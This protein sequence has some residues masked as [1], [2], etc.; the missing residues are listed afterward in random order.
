MGCSQQL[1]RLLTFAHL[2]LDLCQFIL[3]TPLWSELGLVMKSLF[4]F[5]LFS[6]IGFI[7]AQQLPPGM[8]GAPAR[9]H[10][11]MSSSLL[12]GEIVDQNGFLIPFIDCR[13]EMGQRSSLCLYSFCL[14]L[15]LKCSSSALASE[16]RQFLSHSRRYSKKRI[17]RLGAVKNRT[18]MRCQVM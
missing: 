17:W 18:K 10:Q 11:E 13:S 3:P 8:T 6:G 16:Y 4:L 15:F 12:Q 5:L 9:T 1:R 2:H 14:V 7:L